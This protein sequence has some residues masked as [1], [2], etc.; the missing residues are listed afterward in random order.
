MAGI[1][2]ADPSL[3]KIYVMRKHDQRTRDVYQ[4]IHERVAADQ[5]AR[6]RMASMMEKETFGLDPDWFR[7]KVALDAGC[8]NSGFTAARLLDLGVQQ[9]IAMDIGDG[10]QDSFRR[11][12]AMLRGGDDT[13]VTVLAGSTINIPL[14]A[15]SCDFVVSNGVLLHLETSAEAELGFAE[16]SRILVPGGYFY[17]SLSGSGGLLPGVIFP[18][19]RRHYA[20]DPGFKA[21]IDT[22]SPA[23]IHRVIDEMSDHSDRHG[24]GRFDTAMLKSLFGEDF[25]M[26]LK[27][28]ITAPTWYCNEL[29]PQWCET[30]YDHHGF[31]EV[32]RLNRFVVRS[33]IRRFL[34]PLHH[35]IDH[36]FAKVLYGHGVPLFVGRKS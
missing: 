10:W 36:P 27:N 33:D 35:C 1:A 29:T 30:M 20:E 16:C 31:T 7:G 6:A 26:F 32:R 21:F 5:D 28:K 13:R 3:N 34:A 17:L 24:G 12:L 15:G 2:D 14:Q 8:G 19:I 22:I 11:N 18:A 23:A 9:V 25:C 4:E